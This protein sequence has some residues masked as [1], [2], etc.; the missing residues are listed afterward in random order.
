V[1]LSGLACPSASVCEAVGESDSNNGGAV[2]I[3]TTDGG[4]KWVGGE[5]FPSNI[6][7]LTGVACPTTSTCEAVGASYAI[8]SGYTVG[9]DYPLVSCPGASTCRV[10]DGDVPSYPYA[11][12]TTD[13]GARWA[14]TK[15]PTDVGALG[16]IACPTPSVCEAVGSHAAASST[17]AEATTPAV[18]AVRSIDGGTTW[19]SQPL[20]AGI[21]AL[22]SVACPSP[23]DCYAAGYSSAGGLVLRFS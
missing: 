7:D 3:R 20:P 6:A 12:R 16:A 8:S 18:A 11:L 19:A 23:Y 5:K 1:S 2:A 14:S 22:K 15:L 10:P 13:G 21:T 4:V 9:A 17:A